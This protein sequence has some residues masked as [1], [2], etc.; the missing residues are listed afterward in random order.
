MDTVR[1]TRLDQMPCSIARTLDVVGEWWTMLIVRD[2]FRGVTRFD[3]F[4]RRLGIAR[5]VLK[6][7]LDRLVETGI[8]EKRPYETRPPRSE[9][10][11]TDKGRALFPVLIALMQWG[12]TWAADEAGPPIELVHRTC[13]SAMTPHYVCDHCGEPL[14]LGEVDP[15][16]TASRAP[17]PVDG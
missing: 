9:Y 7:R 3:E 17:D 2:A 15:R 8:M 10:V 13:G 11:L 4:H 6:A 14:A 16:P 1:Y 5:T 12:D